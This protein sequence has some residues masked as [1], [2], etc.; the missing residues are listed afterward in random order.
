VRLL[1]ACDSG[2]VHLA[3]A[4][5]APVLALFGPTHRRGGPPAGARACSH[6]RLLNHGAGRCPEGH[7]RCMQDLGADRVLAAVREVL[8]P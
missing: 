7:H 1:V 5:E 8:A 3:A 2:P 4:A 6:S